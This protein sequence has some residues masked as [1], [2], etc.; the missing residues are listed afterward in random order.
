MCFYEKTKFCLDY[1][2]A[3]VNEAKR[4]YRT[5]DGDQLV[6]FAQAVNARIIL[7]CETRRLSVSFTRKTKSNRLVAFLKLTADFEFWQYS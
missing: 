5:C 2:A 4:N 7:N 1:R 3:N 6:Q